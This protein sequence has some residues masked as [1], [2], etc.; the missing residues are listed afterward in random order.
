MGTEFGTVHYPWLLVDNE[1]FCWPRVVASEAVGQQ[2]KP[3]TTFHPCPQWDR[4]LSLGAAIYRFGDALHSNT[5]ARPHQ[6][7]M[8]CGEAKRPEVAC[9]CRE[10]PRPRLDHYGNT[11]HHGSFQFKNAEQERNETMFL[12]IF[13]IL[14]VLWFLG[15]LA[16]H[17]TTGLIHLLLIVAVIALI[18]HFV[19]GRSTV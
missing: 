10:E 4:S 8:G 11:S 16:F 17:V 2:R 1:S 18:V 6:E 7:I 5:Q 3:S 14:L 9:L 12:F 15:F 19:R 13:L